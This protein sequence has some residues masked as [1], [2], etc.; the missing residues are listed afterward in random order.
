M[1]SCRSAACVERVC[2]SA[3][4]STGCI[5]R[6]ASAT[7]RTGRARSA[8]TTS[9]VLFPVWDML[10][11]TANFE[12]RTD[13]TGVRDQLPEAG[14]RDYGR[15][16]WAAAVAGHEA[17][18]RA[19]S[20]GRGV[21]E[22]PFDAFWRAA[23]YCLHP[24][25]DPAV[26]RC[27]WCWWSA[28]GGGARLLLLGAGGRRGARGRWRAGACSARCSPGSNR[29]G[30]AACAASSRHCSSSSWRCRCSSS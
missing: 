1:R 17:D 22:N 2:W 6:S 8:A 25:G 13:P 11:G 14:G 23:A 20:S 15:G 9:R 21:R 3:R 4:A 12:R 24:Q 7:N 30:W 10:F 5:T 19:V 27:R 18:G 16:F 26:A 28:A 29:S